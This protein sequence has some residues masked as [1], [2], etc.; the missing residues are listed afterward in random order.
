MLLSFNLNKYE[1]MNYPKSKTEISFRENCKRYLN[2]V[3]KNKK[4]PPSRH[5]LH[6][7]MYRTRNVIHTFNDTRKVDFDNLL[8]IISDMGL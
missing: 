2:Y 5:K 4:L 6:L 1:E 3:K 8:K 7:W